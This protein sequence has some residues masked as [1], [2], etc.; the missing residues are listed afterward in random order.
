MAE[1]SADARGRLTLRPF[2]VGSVGRRASGWWGML[3][4]VL[5]EAFLFAYLFFSYYYFAVQYGRTWL[6]AELPS[7]WFSV[8]NP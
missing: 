5:T 6:P 8:P 1:A 2:P 4:L 3:T 7:F